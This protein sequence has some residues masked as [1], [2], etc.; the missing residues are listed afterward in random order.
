MKRCRYSIV[1]ICVFLCLSAG[2]KKQQSQCAA[3]L[4][5]FFVLLSAFV[6]LS[7]N[8]QVYG[9][10]KTS[11]LNNAA[12]MHAMYSNRVATLVPRYLIRS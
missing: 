1:L 5:N 10:I 9:N 7:A 12:T 3:V 6:S 2:M 8:R 11:F 4:L